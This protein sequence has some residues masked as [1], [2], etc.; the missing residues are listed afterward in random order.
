MIN[1]SQE[2]RN[3]FADYLEQEIRSNNL[4]IEQMKKINVPYAIEQKTI[5][6]LAYNVVAKIL[7]NTESMDIKNG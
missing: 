2:E 4:I 3:K 6:T 7:K 1:L 5:E